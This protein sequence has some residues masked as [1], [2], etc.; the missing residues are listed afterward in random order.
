ML[1]LLSFLL[2]LGVD[3]SPLSVEVNIDNISEAKGL[4]HVAVFTSAEDFEAKTNPVFE[5]SIS[6]KSTADIRFRIPVSA[7]GF[8]GV[9]LYHDLNSNGELDKNMLGIPKE[10]YA[11][12]NNPAAKWKAPGFE[13]I[14]FAPR[15]MEN[16]VMQLRLATWGE[17]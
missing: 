10:P 9:A 13:E 4:I 17:R 8:H 6:P 5:K 1:A 7:E 3:S 14:A 12:S 16:T 2:A 15:D 11:F